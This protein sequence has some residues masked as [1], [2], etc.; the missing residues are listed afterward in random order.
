MEHLSIIDDD[1]LLSECE[2][3]DSVLPVI[4][5][6]FS[7]HDT[8]VV[9]ETHV[10]NPLSTIDQCSSA[11]DPIPAVETVVIDTSDKLT[12]ENSTMSQAAVGKK[13]KKI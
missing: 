8:G 4:V 13:L 10:E 6:V 7:L 3:D 1:K 12:Q 5:N 2:P 9:W 11:L